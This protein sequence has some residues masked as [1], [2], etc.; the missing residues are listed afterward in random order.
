ML[1]EF[2][3]ACLTNSSKLFILELAFT[4]DI[5]AQLKDTKHAKTEL[6]VNKTKCSLFDGN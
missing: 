2:N 4:P 5:M 1:A 6:D 3:L